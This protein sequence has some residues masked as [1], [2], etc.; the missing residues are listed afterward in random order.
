MKE[1]V[2]LVDGVCLEWREIQC[3]G[4]SERVFLLVFVMFVVFVCCCWDWWCCGGKQNSHCGCL[5]R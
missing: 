2:G 1:G 4:E 5:V 3:V